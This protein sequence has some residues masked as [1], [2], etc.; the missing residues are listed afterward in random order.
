MPCAFGYVDLHCHWVPW[1]DDGAAN[2]ADS[3]AL[4]RVLRDAGFRKVIGTPHMRTGMFDTDRRAI[5]AA[6]DSMKPH[7]VTAELDIEV[8]LSC[9]HFLD[10]VVYQR[11][12]A[13]EGVPY[14]GGHAVLVE[15]GKE[16][17]PA[18]LADRLFDIRRKGLRPVI[19]HPERCHAFWDGLDVVEGLVDRGV[20]LLMDAAAVVGRYGRSTQKAAVQMLEAGLYY[21]VCSDAHRVSDVAGVAA[22][23]DRIRK[24]VGDQEAE[25]LLREGPERVLHGRVEY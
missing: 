23:V 19:A 8:G 13:G 18:M 14:P 21:A 25:F 2:V 1:V 20:V 15:F 5:V 24:L 4:L 6:Y 17:L 3:L 22:G 11:I 7:L 9:E 12:M 16:F 10:D